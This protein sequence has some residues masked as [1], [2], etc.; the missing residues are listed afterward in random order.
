MG[1]YPEYV[2]TSLAPDPNTIPDPG[3]PHENTWYNQDFSSYRVT[4]SPLF[5]KREVRMVVVGAGASGL[6]IAHKA[7]HFLEN[8]T[9]QIYDKNEDVGGT[10]L[11]NRYPGCTCDIPSHS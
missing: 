11:E 4:E 10:W 6:Q 7:E 2:S 5:T 1:S 8:V 9:V 3:A